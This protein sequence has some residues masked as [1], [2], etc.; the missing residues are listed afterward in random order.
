MPPYRVQLR[1]EEI[2]ALATFVRTAWGNTGGPVSE[3]Q[4]KYLREHTDPFSDEVIILQM[5]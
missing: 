1:D 3:E 4:V 5:R 2:A